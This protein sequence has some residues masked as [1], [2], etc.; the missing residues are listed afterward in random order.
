MKLIAVSV[1]ALGLA[2]CL[3][4]DSG[5][6]PRGDRWSSDAPGGRRDDFAIAGTLALL[7][8]AGYLLLYRRRRQRA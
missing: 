6:G 8:G 2:G 5:H 7:S 1:I 3:P 4:E